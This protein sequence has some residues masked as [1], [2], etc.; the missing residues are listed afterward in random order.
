MEAL[1]Y[2]FKGFCSA[3]NSENSNPY[4][5]FG[6]KPLLLGSQ[7]Q[8]LGLYIPGIMVRVEVAAV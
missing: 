2:V 5:I 6:C 8:L 3:Q 4:A 1:E 7:R